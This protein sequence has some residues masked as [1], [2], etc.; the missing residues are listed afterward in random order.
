MIK[1]LVIVKTR[2]KEYM[3]ISEIC[4]CTVAWNA[5]TSGYPYFLFTKKIILIRLFDL[6][7]QGIVP[8][9]SVW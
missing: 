1:G 6:F 8:I 3:G 2:N 5:S 9:I 4:C 7:R